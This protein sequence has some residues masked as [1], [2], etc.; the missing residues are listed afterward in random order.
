MSMMIMMGLSLLIMIVVEIV[1]IWF[2][3]EK[4]NIPAERLEAAHWVFQ[5][6]VVSFVINLLSMPYNACIIAHEKMSVFAYITILDAA[7]KLG[8]A[9]GLLITPFDK[10]ITCNTLLIHFY[11][12]TF[13]IYNIL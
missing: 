12:H 4:L 9:W 3:T 13:C 1:G 10:L 6:S 7:F 8:V 2:L 5:C 11:Y